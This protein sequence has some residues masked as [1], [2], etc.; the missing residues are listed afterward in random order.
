MCTYQESETLRIHNST[1]KSQDTKR[2]LQPVSKV[3]VNMWFMSARIF[4]HAMDASFNYYLGVKYN[5]KE[6]YCDLQ[7]SFYNKTS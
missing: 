3:P 4:Q 5:R 1:D 6:P 7:T 2:E